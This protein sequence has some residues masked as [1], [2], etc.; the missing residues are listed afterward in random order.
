MAFVGDTQNE[1]ITMLSRSD[2]TIYS[3]WLILVPV[4]IISRSITAIG[5]KLR[6]TDIANA[7]RRNK[8]SIAVVLTPLFVRMP[9]LILSG[10]IE[11]KNTEKKIK[12]RT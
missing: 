7:D 8:K 5:S 3:L 11:T 9:I 4:I 6:G 10:R 12:F 1:K 2:F